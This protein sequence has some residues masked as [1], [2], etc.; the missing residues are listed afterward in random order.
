MASV[1][2]DYA[3]LKSHMLVCGIIEGRRDYWWTAKEVYMAYLREVSSDISL[4]TIRRHMA[5]L[6]DLGI[7]ESMVLPKKS[8]RLDGATILWKWEGWLPPI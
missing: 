2:N 8:S 5:N 3:S 1:K 7:I 6:E 4:R